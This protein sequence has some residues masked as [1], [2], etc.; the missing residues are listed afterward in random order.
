MSANAPA[1]TG[2]IRVGVVGL[3]RSGW[4]LHAA[5]VR[6][7]PEMFRL[8]AV[9]DS[10]AE[11]AREAGEFFGCVAFSTVAE[12]AASEQVD[13]VVVATPS[14]L[15]AEHAIQALRH[16]KHVLVEKP[17]SLTVAESDEMM[18]AAR[19]AKRLVVCSQN[20]RYAADFMKVR[21]VID[22]GHL[23]RIIQVNI[24]RHGFRRR[25]DWQTLTKFGGGMLYNDA[26]H[27]VDQALLILGDGEPEISCTLARTPLTLGDA[28]DHVK[29]IVTIPGKPLADLEFSNA[30][31]YPQDQ[32][33]VFGTLGT[34]T[35]SATHLRWRYVD[36]DLLVPREVSDQPTENR[37]Y[38]AE[39]LPWVEEECRLVSEVYSSSHERLYRRFYGSLRL[40]CPPLVTFESVRRQIAVL[41]RCRASI[42]AQI[43]AKNS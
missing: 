15:H 22:S 17:Q 4:D 24:R 33:L 18:S 6:K 20:L 9:A 25:W 34:L 23:G 11:R 42:V 7:L 29:M 32:W 31:A 12:L 21:E 13:L 2:P 40:G 37:G 8:T 1:T 36:P 38:N 3:G 39:E 27:I 14:H 19:Q 28:E 5:T 26:S 35:G 10:M 43:G 30:C 41:E 16:G